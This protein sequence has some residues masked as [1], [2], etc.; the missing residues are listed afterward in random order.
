VSESWKKIQ[1]R[2][3]QSGKSET[4]LVAG[5]QARSVCLA[6]NASSLMLPK[7]EGVFL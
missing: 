1:R 6:A 4:L 5:G 3:G 7:G 2:T